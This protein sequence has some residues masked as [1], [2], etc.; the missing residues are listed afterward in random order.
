MPRR[1]LEDKNIRK[2]TKIGG[3]RSFSITLP[4]DIIRKLGW[5]E[6]QNLSVNLRGDKIIIE[7]WKKK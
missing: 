4:I 5:R 3:G 2:L 1:K 7:D 6:R